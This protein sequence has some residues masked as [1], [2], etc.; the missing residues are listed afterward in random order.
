MILLILFV[1]NYYNKY[2]FLIYISFF[3]FFTLNINN[4][5]DNSFNKVIDNVG[6]CDLKVYDVDTYKTLNK[7]EHFLL[8]YTP[9]FS[10][11]NFMK[12]LC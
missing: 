12:K 6:V 2:N 4:I 11:Y 9:R 5:F 1:V 7:H 3:V 8:Y 10:E